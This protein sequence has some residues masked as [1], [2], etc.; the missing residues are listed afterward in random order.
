MATSSRPDLQR[1]LNHAFDAF[2]AAL[3]Q[4][5]GVASPE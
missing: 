2:R 3:Q 4:M 1:E 5:L